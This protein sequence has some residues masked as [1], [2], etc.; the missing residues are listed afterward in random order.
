MITNVQ[1]SRFKQIEEAALPLGP[2]NVLVGGN[3][4]GKSC[5]LQGIHFGIA[6]AQTRRMVGVQQFPPER[7]RYCPTDDF[8]DLHH[9]RRLQEGT[10][11][12]FRYEATNLAGA[13]DFAAV[14]LQRGR[15]GVVS[16]QSD[17]GDLL[18]VMNDP[19]G[20]FSI[21]VP[22]LAGITIR[23]EYRSDAVVSNGIARGDANLYLRNVLLRIERSG[24]RKAR[25]QEYLSRVFPKVEVATIFQ[26]PSDLWIRST[27]TREGAGTRALDL[28]GTGLLQAI[29][30]IAY[31]S[32]YEPRILLL[33]EPDAHLHPSNQRLL[34]DTLSLIANTT[35]TK[36]ILA[37]HS[38]HLLDALSEL[39]EARLFWV[40]AGAAV[41][42][43]TWSDIAVLM[44]LGALDKGER[45]LAG[46][47]RYLVWSEDRDTEPLSAV[48]EANGI[49]RNDTLVFSYQ[50]SSKVD[51]AKLMA[52]FAERVRP[53]VVTVVHRDRDFMT[54]DEVERLKVKFALD[55]TPNMRLL[56]TEGSDIESY[57][58]RPPHLAQAAGR[59]TADMEAL[60]EDVLHQNMIEFVTAFVRKRDEI[61]RDLY[62]S[63]PSA[64]PSVD[65]FVHGNQI[66]IEQAVG[67]LLL[68]KVRDRLQQEGVNGGAL[69][70]PTP[71]LAD[72]AVVEAFAE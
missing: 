23:E 15:N 22:G 1:L 47:Y 8:L 71:A 27:V 4:S 9:G 58:T 69:V 60:V 32:N 2:I 3:N 34:A 56:I 54:D 53:G 59:E 41:P 28:V 70:Q 35:E 52:A 67:K 43:E 11:I 48:L 42:Q 49:A 46:N 51:A 38:R 10:S 36:V 63:D 25:F 5:I 45:F 6:L 30:L 62:R 33:D 13:E 17:G 14:T 44:D 39:P 29:Q 37:T 7:L 50:A 65:Q 72:T 12:G 64:C 31:V 21:Y 55:Q 61:R 26:E 16:A 57:F 18:S 19:R 24:A 66:A 68:R 40:K 20:F